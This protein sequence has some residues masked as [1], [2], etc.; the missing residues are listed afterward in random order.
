MKKALRGWCCIRAAL[1]KI[2][3]VD[4]FL[5]VFMIIL[6]AQSAYNLFANESVSAETHNI[7]VIVRTSTAAIFGYFLSTNFIC[8]GA[9]QQRRNSSAKGKIMPSADKGGGIRSQMGFANPGT[10]SES[11]I[12]ADIEADLKDSR[13]DIAEVPEPKSVGNV[14][15]SRLQVIT[16]SGIGLFCLIILIV[17][18]NVTGAA[19]VASSASATSTVAQF[20]DIVSGCIGFLIGCPTS[21]PE[22]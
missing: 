22:A 4:K 6:L 10:D 8:R 17:L 5:I 9:S 12:G 1:S 3:L 14:T 11:A 20:R 19:N 13:P 21:D 2:H 7:D 18:R 15:A 16:A